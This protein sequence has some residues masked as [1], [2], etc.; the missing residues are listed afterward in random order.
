MPNPSNLVRNDEPD[1]LAEDLAAARAE[2][3]NLKYAA[4]AIEVAAAAVYAERDELEAELARLRG[5]LAL[6]DADNADLFAANSK[7]LQELTRSRVERGQ[8]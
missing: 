4:T 5:L 3:A 7:L 6:A 8:P 2:I 1:P